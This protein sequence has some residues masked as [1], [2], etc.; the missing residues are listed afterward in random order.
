M[1][2]KGLTLLLIILTAS[3]IYKTYFANILSNIISLE[4]QCMIM[5]FVS[6]ITQLDN[7]ALYYDLNN[8]NKIV[9][10]TEYYIKIIDNQAIQLE[11]NKIIIYN[12]KKI[13]EINIIETVNNELVQH[14]RLKPSNSF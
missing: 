13:N 3:W 1:N 7:L 5:M 2:Y 10:N 4:S 6:I 14:R 8:I 11:K 12:L 9:N